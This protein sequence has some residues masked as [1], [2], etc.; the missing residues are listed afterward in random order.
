VRFGLDQARRGWL[1]PDDVVN[2]RPW[3]HVMRLLRPLACGGCGWSRQSDRGRFEQTAGRTG[4]AGSSNAES[5]LQF[6]L[7]VN[8]EA[9]SF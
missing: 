4:P 5:T 2:T 1:E 8:G 7:K 6:K 3:K 9:R